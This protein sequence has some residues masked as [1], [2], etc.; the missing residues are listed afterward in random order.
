[1]KGTA[2]SQVPRPSRR[3]RH[4]RDLGR[5]GPGVRHARGRRGHRGGLHQPGEGP[6]SPRPGSLRR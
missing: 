6:R 1:M 5:R 4:R 3:E 2:G